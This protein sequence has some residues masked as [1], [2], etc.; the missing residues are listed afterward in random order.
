MRSVPV[1]TSDRATTPLQVIDPATNTTYVLVRMDV[2]EQMRSA[3]ADLDPRA[4][5][6]F[7]EDTMKE[8]D[9]HD[10]LLSSYQPSASRSRKV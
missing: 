3:T 1:H 2:Y 10:P 8:D 4:V 9:L 6:P 5:Y 7:I